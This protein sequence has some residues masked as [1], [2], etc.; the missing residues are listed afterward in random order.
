MSAFR[1]RNPIQRYAWGSPSALPDFLGVDPDGEPWA[2]M[3]MG[4][5][6]RA[7]S[8]VVSRTR[9]RPLDDVI[10]DAP[11]RFLG[12]NRT[13]DDALPFLFKVLA[14]AQPLSIQCHPNDAQAT[15]GYQREEAAGVPRGAPN[16]VYPDPSAKPELVVARSRFTGLKGFRPVEEARA[17]LADYRLDLVAKD[18]PTEE[19]TT[20]SVFAR[21]L[22]APDHERQGWL[23]RAIESARRRSTPEARWVLDLASRYPGDPGALAPL[24]LNVIT[25]APGQALFLDACELHAYLEGLALEIMGNSDNVLRGGLTRKH[26]DV[27]ELLRVLDFTPRRPQPLNPIDDGGGWSVYPTTIPQ[28]SLRTGRVSAAAS[29]TRPV[30]SCLEIVLCTDGELRITTE[31]GGADAPL[32][33]ARGQSAAVPCDVGTYALHGDGEAYVA[34]IGPAVAV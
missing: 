15:A 3:W 28:F 20:R 31:D 5:H 29:L 22:Q 34:T 13:P 17:L 1:L 25:L 10:R 11:D 24:L 26:V 23:E 7:P 14:A 19:A 12:P 30:P 27:P 16:R 8:Q 33:V 2:E 21:V 32:I 9:I 4:A 6:P 18:G